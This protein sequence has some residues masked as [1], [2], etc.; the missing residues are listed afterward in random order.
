MRDGVLSFAL[1]FRSLGSAWL[2][3]S[4]SLQSMN[5]VARIHKVLSSRLFARPEI[6]GHFGVIKWWESRRI[7][8]N[9]LVGVR[10]LLTLAV[11]LVVAAI[12]SAKFN[13]PL[14][15]PDPLIF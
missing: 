14:G 13:E 4:C 15:L 9:L 2:S 5:M 7:L 6:L 8:F 11:I 1:S 12:A 3:S 10:G